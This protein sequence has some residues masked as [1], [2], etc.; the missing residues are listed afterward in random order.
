MSPG[1]KVTR[2]KS[3]PDK[4]SS[5]QKVTWT[6]CHPDKKSPGQKVT[7]TKS[8]PDKKSPE[9]KVTRTKSH[10]DK[11][12]PGQKVTRTKSHPDKKS[13]G[14]KVTRTKSHPDSGKISQ[15]QISRRQTT[16]WQNLIRQ[17]YVRV[18]CR[19]LRTYTYVQTY[20]RIAQF[21]LVNVNVKLAQLGFELLVEKAMIRTHGVRV[22]VCA[23]VCVCNSIIPFF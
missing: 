12:S 22:R 16:T 6:K 17:N 23:C 19:E 8:H 7:R 1:Q 13:P 9:E 20:M 18:A 2:T 3:H 11:K 5:G 15:D 10:P 21:P 4:K 14:Q